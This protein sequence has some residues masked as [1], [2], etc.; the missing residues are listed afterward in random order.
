MLLIASRDAS[1][2]HLLSA[3]T[4]EPTYIIVTC[5]DDLHLVEDVLKAKMGIYNAEVIMS[6]VLTGR[7]NFDIA[8]SMETV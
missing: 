3:S 6:A 8:D 4:P 5:K 7:A 1:I 2:V